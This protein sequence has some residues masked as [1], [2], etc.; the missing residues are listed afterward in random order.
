MSTP[1]LFDFD[2]LLVGKLEG[3]PP[4][5]FDCGRDT[6]TRFLYEYAWHDQRQRV[7]TTYLYQTAGTL[8]AYITVCMDAVPLGRRERPAAIRFQDIPALKLAQL[9][10]HLSLQGRGY[11]AMAVAGVIAMAIALSRYAGCRYVI[12]DAKPDLVEWYR[13]LGFEVNTLK[14]KQ[15]IAAAAGRNP[16]EIPVSMR[17]DLREV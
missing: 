1:F 8:A 16:D 2:D 6:Q 7:S 5:G 9:G 14:Q 17:F 12:L 15:R 11:G 13:G 10:V 3:A 4:P